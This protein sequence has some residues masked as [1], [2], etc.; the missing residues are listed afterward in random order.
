MYVCSLFEFCQE[1]NAYD[2][3]GLVADHICQF[4]VINGGT[5]HCGVASIWWEGRAQEYISDTCIQ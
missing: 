5:T 3:S 4:G 1:S 2:S